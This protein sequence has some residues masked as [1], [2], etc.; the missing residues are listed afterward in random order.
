MKRRLPPGYILLTGP[1][2]DREDRWL[3]RRAFVSGATAAGSGLFAA[4][5]KRLGNIKIGLY[6]I[7]YLGYWYRGDALSMEQLV[8][9][10]RQYGYEGIEIEGKRPHG[11]PLDWP[12]KRCTEFRKFAADNGIVISGVAGNNDFSSPIPEHREAQLALVRDLI[13]MTSELDAKILRVYLAW[14]GATRLPQGGGRYDIAQKIWDV[15]HEDFSQ[16]EAWAWCRE[17]L[18]EFARYAG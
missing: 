12:K 10:A 7:T 1:L 5:G 13:R 6:S 4:S 15:S 16:E 18:I 11:F 2:H 3:T 14:T 8:Q 9:R 17:G